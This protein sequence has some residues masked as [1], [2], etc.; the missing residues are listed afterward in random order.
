MS[1]IVQLPV[2]KQLDK[3][4]LYP[5]Q[6]EGFSWMVAQEADPTVKGGILADEM[7]MGKTIQTIALILA[8]KREVKPTLIVCP[9]SSMSQWDNEI[10]KSM[11]KRAL[12][13]FTFYGESKRSAESLKQFDIVL[14]SY[15]T[16][17]KGFVPGSDSGEVSDSGED[18]FPSSCD[19]G[20]SDTDVD[21]YA[22]S[23]ALFTVKWG[24]VILD[25]GHRI[26]N[27]RNKTTAAI[28]NLKS[29]YHWC[30]T[31]TP[32]HN[33]VKDIHSLVRFLRVDPYGFVF[34]NE[35]DC[36]CV[37]FPTRFCESC[38]HNCFSHFSFFEKNVIREARIRPFSYLSRLLKPILDKVLLRRTKAKVGLDLPPMIETIS[39][40]V[41]SDKERFFYDELHETC[42]SKFAALQ[43]AGNEDR[44]FPLMLSLILQLRQACDHTS[45][46]KFEASSALWKITTCNTD[47]AN[48]CSICSKE[49]GKTR[50]TSSKCPH[51]FHESCIVSLFAEDP[52]I[53][54]MNVECVA[55]YRRDL[56]S[57][58]C[59]SSNA[60]VPTRLSRSSFYDA[61]RFSRTSS[62][63]DAV[64]H[65]VSRTP[66]ES[67]IL[68]FS[69]FTRMLDLI[70]FNLSLQ[71]TSFRKFTGSTNEVERSKIVWEF[72]NS[73]DLR[74]LLISLKAGGEGLNLQSADTVFLTD[75]W[76]NPAVELQAV[77]RVHR[78]GQNSASVRVV[79]FITTD[80]IEERIL[81]LQSTKRLVSDALI[82]SSLEAARKLNSQDIGFLLSTEKFTSTRKKK[83]KGM[84][85]E[86]EPDDAEVETIFEMR[87]SK[88]PFEMIAK[89]VGRSVSDCKNIILKY[90]SCR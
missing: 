15:N 66:P 26:R 3:I 23:S 76:W 50:V 2:P 56:E 55:C 39:E 57:V 64:I 67:K 19:E 4:K 40:V 74:V 70:G 80:S 44:Q 24:R 87:K 52:Y 69:Q 22:K 46:A 34:C 14:T 42:S 38:G 89:S 63:I 11:R 86:G 48:K 45:L 62:K 51:A 29:E 1:N 5:Y 88:I 59:E 30:L 75:P 85:A 28:F 41:L 73:P 53:F 77:Q 7:G 49:L 32:I 37:T 21:R 72:N 36:K 68:I 17:M 8:R 58:N 31:G 71:G 61:L 20:Y 54:R 43:R 6:V 12:K 47:D 10:S 83:R 18:C 84:D 82:D 33:V 35:C 81:H 25:E 79:R 78:V 16:V 60:I 27:G 13:V 65:E 9:M 90:S